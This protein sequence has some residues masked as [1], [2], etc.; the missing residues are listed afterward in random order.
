MFDRGDAGTGSGA[1]T[2]TRSR[3]RSPREAR[4]D[5]VRQIRR[6]QL[7]IEALTLRD[8]ADWADGHGVD[9]SDPFA[10]G[11][12]GGAGKFVASDGTPWIDEF[13]AAEYGALRGT[14]THTA[15]ELIVDALDLRHRMPRLWRAIHELRVPVWMA[16]QIAKAC[17]ELSK[18]AAGKVDA[19]IAGA[20]AGG[21]GW[22]RLSKIV[23]AAVFNADPERA[24]AKVEA[25][26]RRRAVWLS[27][28][29]DG[30]RAMVI[31]ADQGDLL[32]LYA[33]IERI[34][35]IL[36]AD[37]DSDPVDVRRAKA[38]GWLARPE[39]LVVLLYRHRGDGRSA[40]A[41]TDTERREGGTGQA[42]ADRPADDA[43]NA[44]DGGEGA[45]E[46]A[47]DSAAAAEGGETGCAGEDAGAE[48]EAAETTPDSAADDG[49]G[50][51]DTAP[52][53]PATGDAEDADGDGGPASD[54]DGPPDGTAAERATAGSGTPQSG[55]DD[56]EPTCPDD[57]A[58]G[59][60]EPPQPPP[61][62]PGFDWDAPEP[63][64]DPG[65]SD[66]L[67]RQWW[68]HG[69]RCL[70]RPEPFAPV[71]LGEPPDHH[72]FLGADHDPPPEPPPDPSGGLSFDLPRLVDY[73]TARGLKPVPPRVVLHAHLTD[74]TLATGDGVVRCEEAGPMLL[75]Q[76]LDLLRDHSCSIS[77]RPVLDPAD[78]A[79]VDAYE[80]PTGVREAVATR[81]PASVFP[82]SSRSGRG[83]ELDHTRPHTRTATPTGRTGTHNLGPLGK[84][85]H[86][87]KTRGAW[88][89]DQP[90]PGVFIWRSPHGHYFLVTN[91]G[92]QHLGP[93]PR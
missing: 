66:R 53:E 18:E 61:D 42:P 4:A 12:A 30:I 44:E 86:I 57:R 83:M 6:S 8:A 49:A 1:G 69:S 74:H 3:A 84:R 20:A 88:H 9:E 47:G 62:W 17:R 76:L 40:P 29:E 81:N 75:G 43:E 72:P 56:T 54:P 91:Q 38:A 71:W 45:A 63:A 35:D 46:N 78:V 39:D 48:P 32:V 34:A 19:E 15:T 50:V 82:Y 52:G 92:T 55:T 36:A 13:V 26:R 90:H 5:R 79:A 70:P 89:V 64:W 80:I 21:L 93:K 27:D 23:A 10:T 77:L 60:P 58:D 25:A 24:K 51:D 41:P 59:W 7:R 22:T 28:S 31:R 85:E 33:L 37:G 67:P 68:R 65:V 87:I 11:P 2:G 14:T 16:R 73:L